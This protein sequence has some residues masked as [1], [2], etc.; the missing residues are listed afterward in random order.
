VPLVLVFN[1]SNEVLFTPVPLV[2]NKVYFV[3][4]S[5]MGFFQFTD[6]EVELLIETEVSPNS[7]IF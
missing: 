3:D 4:V 5:Q 2:G 6:L 1:Q 7:F